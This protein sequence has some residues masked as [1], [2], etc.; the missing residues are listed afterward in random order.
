MNHIS[1]EFCDFNNPEH[2]NALISLLSH[3]MA[4]PM[5]DYPPHDEKKQQILLEG[6]RNHP[7]AFILF[8]LYDGSYAGMTTCFV[9]YSTFKLK[10]YLYVHDVVILK[11]LRCKGLGKAMMEKLVSI[12]KER[13][14]CKIA[15]EVREDNPAAQKL[16]KSL[17]FED[18]NPRMYYWEK[19]L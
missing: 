18:C 12:S 2:Q 8:L 17:G 1:F 5:G 6:L 3:Y 4:D 13:D 10:P 11:E 14:Y 9:N 16:Y 7:T 19:L 15:L